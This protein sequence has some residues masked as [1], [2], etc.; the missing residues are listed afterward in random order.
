MALFQDAVL[1]GPSSVVQLLHTATM[2]KSTA[3]PCKE[4]ITSVEDGVHGA[5][6]S[7]SNDRNLRHPG[8]IPR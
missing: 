3:C 2:N 7:I 4:S 6:G 1:L 8:S 5:K